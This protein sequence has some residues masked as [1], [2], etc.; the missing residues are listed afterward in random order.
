MVDVIAALETLVGTLLIIL[1][2]Y[3]YCAD[4]CLKIRLTKAILGH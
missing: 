2:F 1:N 4:N 3:D